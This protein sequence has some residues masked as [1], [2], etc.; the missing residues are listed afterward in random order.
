MC[1]RDSIRTNAAVRRDNR[2]LFD[3]VAILK[4][5]R[6]LHDSSQLNLAPAPADMRR[7]QGINKISSLGL[8]LNLRSRESFYLLAQLRVSPDPGLFHFANFGI[9]AFE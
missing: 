2:F 6:K 7:A 4:H 5:A 3:K 9:N 8:Q 1:I